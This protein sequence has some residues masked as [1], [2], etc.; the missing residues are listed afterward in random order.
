MDAALGDLDRRVFEMNRFEAH[1]SRTTLFYLALLSVQIARGFVLI[2]ILFKAFG[3]ANYGAYVIALSWMVYCAAF[4]QLGLDTT[5][6]QHLTPVIR[7]KRAGPV[8]WSI[9]RLAVLSNSIV[10]LLGLGIVFFWLGATWMPI[11]LACALT[12]AAQVFWGLLLTPF[13][14]EERPALFMGLSTL[15]ALGDFAITATTA[16]LT[17]ELSS[18]T[19]AWA[20]Y[21]GCLAAVMTYV[22]ARRYP[23]S[24]PMA[25]VAPLLRFGVNGLVNQL[26]AAGYYVFDRTIISIAAGLHS[27]AAYAPGAALGVALQP[28][29][30][31]AAMTLP[32]LLVMP[33]VRGSRRLKRQILRRIIRNYAVMAIPAC[34]GVW[35]VASPILALIT[36]PE[37]AEVSAPVARVAALAVLIGGLSRFPILALRAEHEDRWLSTVLIACFTGFVALLV[38]LVV[39]R[40]AWAPMSAAISI[41]AANVAQLLPTFRRLRRHIDHVL[42]PSLF[43]TPV[44]AAAAMCLASLAFQPTT[45]P[46]LIGFVAACASIYG[47]VFLVVERVGPREILSAVR[48]MANPLPNEGAQGRGHRPVIILYAGPNHLFSSAGAF[49]AAELSE[50]FDVHVV[51][52]RAPIAEPMVNA[53]AKRAV[54]IHWIPEFSW[55]KKQ[56]HNQAL[57]TNLLEDL[58]PVGVMSI[59]DYG[60]FSVILT[61]HAKNADVPVICFQTGSISWD[62]CIDYTYALAEAAERSRGKGLPAWMGRMAMRLRLRAWHHWHYQ[63]APVLAGYAPFAGTSS[64]FLRRGHTGQRACDR[65]LIYDPLAVEIAVAAGTP[66]AMIGLVRHPMLSPAGQALLRELS[67]ALAF[68]EPAAMVLIDLPIDLGNVSAQDPKADPVQAVADAAI[69]LAETLA[70]QFRT[71]LFKPHPAMRDHPRLLE[72]L[73]AGAA[74]RPGVLLIEPEIDAVSLLPRVSLV[75]GADSTV[76]SIA[77][78]IP[79]IA[80]M[81]ATFIEPGVAAAREGVPGHA[82]RPGRPDQGGADW[83]SGSGGSAHRSG[84]DSEVET[85]LLAHVEAVLRT[86]GESQAR[87]AAP[88]SSA[89]DRNAGANA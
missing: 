54:T 33:E 68:P 25:P 79:G 37:L 53:L 2:P 18:V 51:L 75:V 11:A 39:S 69:G 86:H 30:G 76:L 61:T 52:H 49:Y 34:V 84:F 43:M 5:A 24:P 1:I 64:V 19:L 67:S 72:L 56:E 9:L 71:V 44:V 22:Q 59:D 7:T 40:P 46:S 55:L 14:C 80:V 65:F 62:P 28:L 77:R 20:I 10:A 27:V 6:Y 78:L 63:V 17:G 73:R 13:R 48:S 58:R 15:F 8:L 83:D 60:A 47:F 35:L 88:P 4:G 81:Q 89:A 38:G 50:T 85:G 3:P 32:T 87:P 57:V 23:P 26:I 82:A 36:S 70:G 21:H 31:L 42:A 16:A 45:A 74:D 29:S 66:R 12:A 41:L